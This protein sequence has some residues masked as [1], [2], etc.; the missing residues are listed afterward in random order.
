MAAAGSGEG[1][2]T[3]PG[4]EEKDKTAQFD[5]GGGC[6]CVN[7]SNLISTILFG[8]KVSPALKREKDLEAGF[9]PGDQDGARL[10]VLQN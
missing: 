7:L 1:D 9:K 2:Q 10:D 3:G 8:G 4:G 5:P 6:C